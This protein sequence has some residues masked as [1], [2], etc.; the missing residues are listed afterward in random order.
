MAPS[1]CLG[2][3]NLS[4]LLFADDM[5]LVANGGRDLQILVDLILITLC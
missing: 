5:A 3:L 1:L 4:V 2:N